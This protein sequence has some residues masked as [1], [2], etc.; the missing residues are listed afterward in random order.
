MSKIVLKPLNKIL[1]GNSR[2]TKG[3]TTRLATKI[4][5]YGYLFF[6]LGDLAMK[7]SDMGRRE[8]QYSGPIHYNDCEVTTKM[9]FLVDLFNTCHSYSMINL[10][11]N[12]L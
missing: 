9:D 10:K 5:R 7:T 12:T 8:F 3:I 6:F 11:T 4:H 1:H 2:K